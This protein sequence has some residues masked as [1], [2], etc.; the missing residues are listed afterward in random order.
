MNVFEAIVLYAVIWF[1]MIFVLLPFGLRTQGDE[2]RIVPGT[3]AG[4]PADFRVRRL[5]LWVTVATTVLWLAAVLALV[6][7]DIGVRDIDI[8]H[9]MART[10]VN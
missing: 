1:M 8:F 3:H 5:L 10:P 4:A 2:G 9:R 6:Y 7:S